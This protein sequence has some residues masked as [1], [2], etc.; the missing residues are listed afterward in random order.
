MKRERLFYLDFI[1]AVAAIAIVLTH[2]NARQLYAGEWTHVILTSD[3]GGLYIGD[4]GVSLFF[5]ISGAALMYVYGEKCNVKDFW[6]KRF[7]S[8]YPMFWIAYTVYFA[9]YTL[10]YRTLPGKEGTPLWKMIF[11]VIGF[12]GLLAANG[13]DTFYLLGE[14]FLGV[15]VLLYFIFPFL[16]KLANK[17]TLL[18]IGAAAVSYVVGMAV[19]R[20]APFQLIPATLIL[21]RIPEIVFGMLFVKHQCKADLKAAALAFVVV[22][23]NWMLKP[24]G[25]MELQTIYVGIASFYLLVCLA[26]YIKC[27]PVVAVCNGL[28]KYSYA[29]F[30]VHHVIIAEITDRVGLRKL[31]QW[32]NYLLF[33]VICI[34]IGICSIS[35]FQIHKLVMQKIANQKKNA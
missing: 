9:C 20:Y 8:I 11:S 5:I 27:K 14:W 4:W 19:C 6:K 3:V 16:R 25:F 17:S 12:D 33:L 32:Q 10:E 22:I 7:Y 30:L 35:L 26:K 15:I 1:R 28:S 21:V 24:A 2:F 34:V 31:T 29:I 23:G 13:Q 18:C